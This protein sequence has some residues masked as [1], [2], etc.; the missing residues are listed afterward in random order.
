MEKVQALIETGI[1]LEI[2]YKHE[3]GAYV[4]LTIEIEE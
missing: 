3:G 2:Y 4:K 1:P